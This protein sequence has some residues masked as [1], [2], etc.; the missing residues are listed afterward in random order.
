MTL[1]M[2]GFPIVAEAKAECGTFTCFRVIIW[3]PKPKTETGRR[4]TGSVCLVGENLYGKRPM[5]ATG[6]LTCYYDDDCG[7]CEAAKSFFEHRDRNGAIQFIGR[8]RKDEFRHHAPDD[9]TDKTIVVYDAS[10]SGPFIRSRAFARLMGALPGLWPLF[11]VLGWPGI[12]LFSDLGYRCIAAN[13]ARIS[14][15]LG[16]QACKLPVRRAP[17]VN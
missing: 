11:A 12:S 13:R 6:P 3:G 7:F 10:G 2:S 9:L 1:V 17:G 8:S 14:R 4:Q 15:W 16:L 5:P